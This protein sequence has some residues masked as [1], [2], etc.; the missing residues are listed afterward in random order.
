MDRREL[1]RLGGAGVV[2][3]LGAPLLAGCDPV[4]LRYGSLGPPDANGLRLPA[5][6]TSRLVATSGSVVAGTSHVWHAAPDGGACF[7]APGG[8]WVYVSN[9]EVPGPGGG[10]GALRFDPVGAIVGACTVASGTD[11][12]CAG[13]AT[14]WGT[15]LTCEESSRGR[16]LECD[17]LAGG[18]TARPALGLFQHEAAAV[19]PS[20]GHV[21]LTEDRTDG[22]FYRFRPTVA[23]D[24]AD[25]ALEVLTDVGGT[26]GWAPIPDP[27]AASVSTR[28]QVATA[29][30]FTG[31][32]GIWHHGGAV[33]F[34]TK[35]DNRVWRHGLGTGGGAGTLEVFYEATGSTPLTG[36]DNIAGSANGDLW[37]AEDGGDLQVCLVDGG[38]NVGAFLQLTGRSGT[39]LTGPAFSPDGTRLYVSSQRNP[40]ETFEI[41]GPF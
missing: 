34:S 13:G 24:L 25:G 18:A 4:Q 30:H 11:R 17:P 22:C 6:F 10:V 9:S 32:E 8:G 7:P 28:Y 3:A 1:L 37:V 29:R 33:F 39:E 38:G 40:G 23:G 31:G 20:S 27:R 19:V 15:W 36:V 26:L 41:T 16:V 14:T 2:F 35:G 21:Y 5:G 12:N